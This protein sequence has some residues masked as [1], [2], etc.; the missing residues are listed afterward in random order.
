MTI[1]FTHIPKCGGTSFR[2][3]LKDA[4]ADR[5][6]FYYNNPI[7]HRWSDRASY[8]IWRVKNCVFPSNRPFSDYEIVYG[9]YDFDDVANL[10]GPGDQFGAFLRDPIEWFGSL[11]FYTYQKYPSE[12]SKDPLRFFDSVG[13]SS[14]FRLYLGRRG[15]ESLDFVGLTERYNE[16]LNLFA[17]MFGK[18]IGRHFDNPTKARPRSY[19]EYF[20]EEGMLD[21]VERRLSDSRRIYD[22]AV[23]RFE[24]LL[25]ACDASAGL[26]GAGE[27]SSK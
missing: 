15:V 18:R 7:R 20:A 10:V 6:Y 21:E 9:H 14:G 13:L 3:G 17:R 26:V 5:A 23:S 1:Y 19:A 12:V 2:N 4:Y 16:S 8:R 24:G 22:E 25:K 27:G 11:Y